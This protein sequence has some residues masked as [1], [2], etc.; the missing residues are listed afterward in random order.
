MVEIADDELDK[1]N[2][3]AINSLLKAFEE[4]ID[5]NSALF[6]LHFHE[7]PS[8]GWKNRIEWIKG[9]RL[10]YD[11]EKI[12]NLINQFY[13]NKCEKYL[14]EI[15]F[16]VKKNICILELNHNKTNDTT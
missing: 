1:N 14:E 13:Q 6:N 5:A 16:I 4:I 11:W 2:Y 10:Y 12:I 8:I 9:K 3:I 7:E 15:I